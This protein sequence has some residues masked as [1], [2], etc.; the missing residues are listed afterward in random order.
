MC[1][2]CRRLVI[3]GRLG[4][5]VILVILVILIILVILVIPVILIILVEAVPSPVF[6]LAVWLARGQ[7]LQHLLQ[8]DPEVPPD[9]G[10]LEPLRLRAH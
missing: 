9:E 5:L 8:A 10:R 6:L 1:R 2:M 4:R 3:L 7:P